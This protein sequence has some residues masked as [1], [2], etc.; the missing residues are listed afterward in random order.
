[1]RRLLGTGLAVAA[2]SLPA[3]SASAATYADEFTGVEIP[4]V[5]STLG[6]FTGVATGQLPGVWYAQIA[7]EPLSTGTTVAITG[8][9]FTVYT[10]TG[11]TISGGIT[12]GTV[13]VTNLGSGCR[14]QT[15][16]VNATLSDG[17]FTGT[18]THYRYSFFGSCITYSASIVGN[19]TI[20][21]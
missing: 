5:T 13:T 9:S 11:R 3:A 10:I 16:T 12:G 7:H 8:G 4:P 17:N 15:F 20:N 14:N 19:G 18:L 2:L 1:M 6:T 21:A